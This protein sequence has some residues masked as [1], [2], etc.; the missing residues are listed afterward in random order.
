MRRLN[1][2]PRLTCKPLPKR[3]T[4]RSCA[5]WLLAQ[6]L[7]KSLPKKPTKWLPTK[8]PKK[9]SKTLSKTPTLWPTPDPWWP[10]LKRPWLLRKPPEWSCQQR[11][12]KN[13]HGAAMPGLPSWLATTFLS[14]LKQPSCKASKAWAAMAPSPCSEA[15]PTLLVFHPLQRAWPSSAWPMH[16][17]A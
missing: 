8:P 1:S 2:F 6:R 7:L 4:N 3:C 17:Q 12:P 15:K 16:Q 13:S 5:C 14:N 9:P 11:K 10:N